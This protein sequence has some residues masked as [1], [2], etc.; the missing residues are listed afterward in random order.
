M[1][2]RGV[3]YRIILIVPALCGRKQILV[4]GLLFVLRVAPPLQVQQCHVSESGLQN[5]EV[6][7][8]LCTMKSLFYYNFDFIRSPFKFNTH[9]SSK[10]N[11]G[12][13][14]D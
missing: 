1:I 2:L 10:A 7:T 9:K 6:Y 8:K 14:R 11:P 5:T 13:I 12:S 3:C 4:S